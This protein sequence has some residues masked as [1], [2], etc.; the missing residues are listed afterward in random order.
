MEYA[1]I[2]DMMDVLELSGMRAAFGV[3]IGIPILPTPTKPMV[4][5]AFISSDLDR[6]V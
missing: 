4:R 2:L 1:R 5:I 3:F 6:L